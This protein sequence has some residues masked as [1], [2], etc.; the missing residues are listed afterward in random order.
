MQKSTNNIRLFMLLWSF[1]L[2]LSLCRKLLKQ[3][4]ACNVEIIVSFSRK[5][6]TYYSHLNT[7]WFTIS[8]RS[9][10]TTSP[11]NVHGASYYIGLAAPT[12]YFSLVI[13][14]SDGLKQIWM[15][16]QCMVKNVHQCQF[17]F[18]YTILNIN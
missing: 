9:F 6:L 7:T 8:L 3:A 18:L 4:N 16:Q 1:W 10:V 2:F 11:G 15:C 12:R 13:S 14:V 5:H 17:I